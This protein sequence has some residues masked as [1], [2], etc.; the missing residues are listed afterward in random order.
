MISRICSSQSKGG[1]NRKQQKPAGPR[2]VFKDDA[3][4]SC[5]V[6][7]C[8]QHVSD[9]GAGSTH[10]FQ[11][12]RE[13][14]CGGNSPVVGW[15]E[16]MIG[17]DLWWKIVCELGQI[18]GSW[19]EICLIKWRV[20]LDDCPSSLCRSCNPRLE[21]DAMH[22]WGCSRLF[23]SHVQLQTRF[24]FRPV[25]HGPSHRSPNNSSVPAWTLQA[26]SGGCWS[27]GWF[28]SRLWNW[29][30]SLSGSFQPTAD[31]FT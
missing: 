19:F 31:S 13:G 7:R 21:E 29:S 15:Q 24:G 11:C 22:F 8:E 10:P 17:M 30:R 5:E 16:R 20:I 27:A 14:G 18:M 26:V 1:P 4:I 3:S 25:F 6:T 28:Q 12:W 2:W 9:P 23:K